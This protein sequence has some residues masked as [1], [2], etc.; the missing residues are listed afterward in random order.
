M[1]P[2]SLEIGV[3]EAGRG[4]VLGPL[5]MA[6]CGLSPLTA[7]SLEA[8]GVADSKS[9]G[10]PRR[11]QARRAA[12]AEEIR[13]RAEWWA[14]KVVPV[15]DIDAAV[16]RGHLNRLERQVAQTLLCGA[17]I[18]TRVV[19]DG[20][21]LFQ[22][23]A[24][25]LP[26]AEVRNRAEETSLSVAA[27]SI[28]A[29]AERDRLFAEIRAGYESRFGPLRGEGYPNLATARFLEAYLQAEGDLPMETRR[30]WAWAPVASR[31]TPGGSSGSISFDF[32]EEE[33]LGHD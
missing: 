7:V 19:L 3:D 1:D 23:L 25:R 6:A 31:L 32:G 22:S 13:N 30:S 20:V 24:A 29:K 15:T 26:R 11:A 21:R 17:P 16:T 10:A 33:P 14:L 18:W 27:A 5:V 9:F 2:P 12:L 4:A 8:L 28:L